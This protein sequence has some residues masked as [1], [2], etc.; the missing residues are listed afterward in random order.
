MNLNPWAS[1]VALFGKTGTFRRWDW[2][3]YI[4]RGRALKMD[5]FT[6]FPPRV[7]SWQQK[8]NT[9]SKASQTEDQ[10]EATSLPE[11]TVFQGRGLA[12]MKERSCIG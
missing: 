7:S 12:Q 2:K 8:R 3:N 10:E 6:P 1:L 11:G 9:S 5:S 4:T